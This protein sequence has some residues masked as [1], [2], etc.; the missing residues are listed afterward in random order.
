M[1]AVPRGGKAGRPRCGTRALTEISNRDMKRKKLTAEEKAEHQKEVEEEIRL[2][3]L[4]IEHVRYPATDNCL[5]FLSER[6]YPGCD[7]LSD[8]EAL[9]AA[10]TLDE[11]LSCYE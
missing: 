6:G 3:C 2:S 7:D 11:I 8:S 10:T 4:F 9:D 5:A 1:R